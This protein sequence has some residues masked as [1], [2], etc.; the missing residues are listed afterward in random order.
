[1]NAH[2]NIGL[3]PIPAVKTTVGRFVVD[4]RWHGELDA[5][6]LDKVIG[7]SLIRHRNI[8][9]WPQLDDAEAHNNRDIETPNA[10]KDAPAPIE[11]VTWLDGTFRQRAKWVIGYFNGPPK[12]QRGGTLAFEDVL[13]ASKEYWNRNGDWKEKSVDE[14]MSDP[15]IGRAM[16]FARLKHGQRLISVK[17]HLDEETPHIHVISIALVQ[18]WHKVRGRKPLSL[19]RDIHGNPIDL[20]EK[21]LKYTFYGSK[22]RGQKWQLARNH[23][24]WATF[25]KDLGLIRGSDSTKMSTEEKRDRDKTYTGMA[26]TIV[27]AAK[28]EAKEI[29]EEAHR[30]AQEVKEYTAKVVRCDRQVGDD[31]RIQAATA[32]NALMAEAENN[33]QALLDEAEQQ[34]AVTRAAVD[35]EVTAKLEAAERAAAVIMA[36]A[37]K[38][39]KE[40]DL[41]ASATSE[42]A[43]RIVSD[44]RIEAAALKA[45]AAHEGRT[46]I[47][48]A[49]LDA[50][51][52]RQEARQAAEKQAAIDAAGIREA[53]EADVARIRCEIETERQRNAAWTASECARL[54]D[55]KAKAARVTKTAEEAQAKAAVDAA[56]VAAREEAV[57]ARE[58][59]IA[60]QEETVRA[61]ELSCGDLE[62]R[63]H[64]ALL[65]VDE[66]AEQL[67][68]EL[69]NARRIGKAMRDHYREFVALPP[70]QQSVMPPQTAK[71]AVV[72][73]SSEL[74]ELKQAIELKNRHYEWRDGID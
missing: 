27:A 16:E 25:V 62:Q 41:A 38:A 48:D 36:R 28:Q 24:E 46:I 14:I 74:E 65:Q 66:R 30:S 44:A 58:S 39:R 71:A 26:S 63:L 12:L 20:R 67:S 18:G 3:G 73:Q 31:F 37:N 29:L 35:A 56:A 59:Q 15:F 57:R 69:E 5:N 55:E 21:E 42:N 49:R 43:D 13:S 60:E 33:A 34:A 7:Y 9:S 22:L 8:K 52:F 17:V 40:A 45:A 32:A 68:A 1:M 50:E 4:S 64:D 11:L 51:R 23:D 6:T 70:H 19:P 2:T 72:S 10:R 53:A 47:D 54:R 61:N